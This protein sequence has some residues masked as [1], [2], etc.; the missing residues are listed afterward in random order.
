MDDVFESQRS[1]LGAQS[2]RSQMLHIPQV[3]ASPIEYPAVPADHP[4]WR[5]PTPSLLLNPKRAA[6]N[7]RAIQNAFAFC[8]A[9]VGYAMKANPHPWLLSAI[10][11]VEGSLFEI[12]S[13]AEI[14]G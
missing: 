2:S 8:D 10:A 1:Y 7:F 14:L 13:K 3:F 11:D 5:V 12:A 4:I 6:D 9:Q